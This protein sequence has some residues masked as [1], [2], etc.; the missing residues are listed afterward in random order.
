MV[1]INQCDFIERGVNATKYLQIDRLF[2]IRDFN[3]EFEE[4]EIRIYITVNGHID[5]P[6]LTS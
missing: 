4:A 1:E 2:L 3:P 5:E 6:I